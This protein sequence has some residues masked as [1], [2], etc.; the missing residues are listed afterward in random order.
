MSVFA[1][2]APDIN[3]VQ[4]KNFYFT[5]TFSPESPDAY[6]DE[7]SFSLDNIDIS[8]SNH[9][10][11]ENLSLL[12]SYSASVIFAVNLPKNIS[13]SFRIN[14]RGT[15]T[16]EGTEQ[17]FE[18]QP[19]TIEFDTTGIAEDITFDTT[20]PPSGP[21]EV[22][23]SLSANSISNG[24]T[25]IAQFD[26]DY[27]NHNFSESQ[28][29]VTGGAIKGNATA[30]DDYSRRWIVPVTV[31]DTGEGEV[32]IEIEED[33][34]FFGSQRASAPVQ[35]QENIELEIRAGDLAITPI[36]GA[37]LNH[38]I[39]ITGNNVNKVDIYGVLR[40]F[41]H[42]WDSTAGLLY[43]RS[44]GVVDTDYDNFE[45][46]V[47]ARDDGD[48][49]IESEGTI[50]TP[51]PPAPI[52]RVPTD[53][54]QLVFGQE[55]DVDIQIDND[56]SRVIVEGTWLGLNHRLRSPGVNI[57]GTIPA[58]GTDVGQMIPGTNSGF[59]EVIPSNAGGAGLL[60]QVP[61]VL[62]RGIKPQWTGG[63]SV[64]S[65]GADTV[66]D[67]DTVSYVVTAD[68]APE[69][70]LGSGSTIP[71]GLTLE[72]FRD[73]EAAT[74]TA[75]FTGT[76]DTQGTY[77]FTLVAKNA[78]GEV[79]SFAQRIVITPPLVAPSRASSPTNPWTWRISRVTS[80]DIS[81][82]FNRGNPEGIFSFSVP[83]S[84]WQI[85]SDGVVT[86]HGS[87]NNRSTYNLVVFCHNSEGSAHILFNFRMRP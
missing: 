23:I 82:F 60:A 64:F 54:V 30:L 86:W 44:I 41:Y 63:S 48:T 22:D 10:T 17:R 65:S 39:T 12:Y 16:V 34:L 72:T 83:Q 43:V 3:E 18:Y 62:S 37:V 33:A 77:N 29:N 57:F 2:I 19:K 66:F 53:P 49:P 4:K 61:W 45:F 46:T 84:L 26:F 78:F 25:I 47:F 14:L 40:P 8:W 69:I 51:T 85:T 42:H 58:R 20:P 56:P 80:R 71:T 73:A 38:P 68:P 15:V 75:Y 52:V 74:T 79:R 59:W 35:H 87:S 55:V 13:G 31:P 5:I 67:T 24:G 9:I 1:V 11:L 28:V 76:A 36:K 6:V 27:D 81:R 32:E 50:S 70:T 21:S 7:G